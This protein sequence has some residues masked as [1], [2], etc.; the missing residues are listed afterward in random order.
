MDYGCHFLQENCPLIDG[1]FG[2]K[3]RVQIAKITEVL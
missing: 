1:L 3:H 2:S